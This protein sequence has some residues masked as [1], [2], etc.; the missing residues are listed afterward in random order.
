MELWV[1]FI[2]EQTTLNIVPIITGFVAGAT[3]VHL[4]LKDQKVWIQAL[5]AGLGGLIA[6]LISYLSSD[7]PDKSVEL[8][9]I[10][11]LSIGMFG[12]PFLIGIIVFRAQKNKSKNHEGHPPTGSARQHVNGSFELTSEQVRPPMMQPLKLPPKI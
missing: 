1:K 9:E 3:V 7:T 8:N 11:I 12:F 6:G 5:T 2:Y 10:L 4:Y